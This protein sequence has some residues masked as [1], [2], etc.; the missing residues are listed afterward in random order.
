MP[1]LRNT[2]PVHKDEKVPVL[3]FSNM[4]S[5]SHKDPH[6]FGGVGAAKRGLSHLRIQ[7]YLDL[8]SF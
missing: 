7:K 2:V 6:Y 3:Y 4:R 8:S 1:R 5:R